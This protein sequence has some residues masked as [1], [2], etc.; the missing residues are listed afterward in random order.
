[1]KTKIFDIECHQCGT[2]F[3]T[4]FPKTKYCGDECKA[5]VN[6]L[7]LR[8]KYF[9]H[10]A[11]IETDPKAK[12]KYLLQSKMGFNAFCDGCGTVFDTGGIKAVRYCSNDCRIEKRQEC[13][14]IRAEAK[15]ESMGQ[16]PKAERKV[17]KTSPK[18]D[19]EEKL[20]INPYFLRRGNP[21]KTTGAASLFNMDI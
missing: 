12:E 20:V 14:V 2:E 11:K 9:R 16:K 15:K 17:R 7:Q 19:P 5:E 18:K 10:K 3:Q 13:R 21:S 6:K 4:K 1:M 8:A